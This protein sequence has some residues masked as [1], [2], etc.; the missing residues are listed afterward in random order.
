MYVYIYIC[1]KHSSL[2][3]HTH[4]QHKI[5]PYHTPNPVPL[6]VIIATSTQ[7]NSLFSLYSIS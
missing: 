4:A 2:I 6:N 5:N 1:N 7:S 3:T